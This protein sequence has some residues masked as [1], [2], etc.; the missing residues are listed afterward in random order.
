MV[1]CALTMIWRPSVHAFL[2]IRACMTLLPLSQ[3]KK[4]PPYFCDTCTSL[5]CRIEPDGVLQMGPQWSSF[6]YS[7]SAMGASDYSPWS[8]TQ[9]LPVCKYYLEPWEHITRKPLWPLGSPHVVFCRK[10]L[11]LFQREILLFQ[12]KCLCHPLKEW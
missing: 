7:G 8:G 1:S 2:G 6:L 12:I 5:K 11:D 4:F 9:E 10:C 3:P